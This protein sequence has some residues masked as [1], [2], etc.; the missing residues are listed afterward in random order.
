VDPV[1]IAIGQ[2][3]TK[4]AV[5]AIL[6]GKEPSTDDWAGAVTSVLSAAFSEEADR[7]SKQLDR[8]ETK[9]DALASQ[10]Y[11]D[12]IESAKHLCRYALSSRRTPRDRDELLRQARLEL[13]H[14]V[15]AAGTELGRRAIAYWHL[16]VVHYCLQEVEDSRTCIRAAYSDALTCLAG[17]SASVSR[18]AQTLIIIDDAFRVRIDK[19]RGSIL[20]RSGLDLTPKGA[21]LVADYRLE[22]LSAAQDLE[23]LLDRIVSLQT[24]AGPVTGVCSVQL[25][26]NHPYGEDGQWERTFFG[27]R[28][29]FVQEAQARSACMPE[30]GLNVSLQKVA[31]ADRA[32][33]G[34]LAIERT[35]RKSSDTFSLWLDAWVPFT[36]SK[37]TDATVINIPV[38]PK[39]RAAQ[40]DRLPACWDPSSNGLDIS[41][42]GIGSGWVPFRFSEYQADV[43]IDEAE[44]ELNASLLVYHRDKY[45]VFGPSGDR[46]VDTSHD[47]GIQWR[48]RFHSSD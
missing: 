9:I 1:T 30:V 33:L 26:M 19:V 32:V 46:I 36:G 35:D 28:L 41:G 39:P 31:K 8:I 15:S 38:V 18:D 25:K 21:D 45:H 37:A 10:R 16:A 3:A 34:Y 20:D 5:R 6:N 44:V 24:L 11:D 17:H 27:A 13:I 2:A 22:Q 12:A 42:A 47:H 23:L 4:I 48:V 7:S 29:G 43:N 14:A 40:N